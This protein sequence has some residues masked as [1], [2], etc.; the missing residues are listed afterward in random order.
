MHVTREEHVYKTTE[1]QGKTGAERDGG[2]GPKS[3]PFR[4]L[5]G[6]FMGLK[7]HQDLL[8]TFAPMGD[9]STWAREGAAGLGNLQN[10]G[11]HCR[12]NI[13]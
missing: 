12:E 7:G 3:K 11:F 10:R 4:V 1:Q 9:R 5:V 13:F 6:G 2:R 8:V